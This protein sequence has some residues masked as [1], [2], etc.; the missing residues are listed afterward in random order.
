[1]QVRKRNVLSICT[2]SVVATACLALA[3]MATGKTSPMADTPGTPNEAIAALVAGNTRYIN[4]KTELSNPAKARKALAAGQAPFAAILRCADSRV[5]PEIVFDQPL[6][7]LF[8]CAVA[9]NIPTMEIIASLEYGVAVLGTKVIV[10]MGHS[11]CGAV[12][13]AIKMR[14]DTSALPG[15][16]PELIDQIIIPCTV[17][18]DPSDP[19]A[20][21]RAVECNA[22]R[23]V[24]SLM[25]RSSVIA[26]AVKK[27]D[28]KVIAGVQDLATGRF[29]IT[30]K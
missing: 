11:S 15:S 30:S 14:K 18:S 17:N 19:K 22:N 28:L 4:E 9:G 23:G 16:L 29:S 5:A 3:P 13:T 8:V 27:G 20:M 1:M 25:K 2:L 26:D 7:E 12:E 21:P 6:G 10:I 24:E